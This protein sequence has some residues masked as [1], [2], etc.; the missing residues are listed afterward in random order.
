ML[1]TLHNVF[2][3]QFNLEK[4]STL[5]ISATSISFANFLND[6]NDLITN[7]L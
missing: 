7:K 1:N 3:E 5:L 4:M 6:Q 2:P